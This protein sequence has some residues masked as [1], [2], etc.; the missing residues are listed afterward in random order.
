MLS[1]IRAQGDPAR[2]RRDGGGG[3]DMTQLSDEY[4]NIKKFPEPLVMQT[5]TRDH[6]E[7]RFLP[8]RRMIWLPLQEEQSVMHIDTGKQQDD[9][10]TMSE[11]LGWSFCCPVR[12][13]A[14]RGWCMSSPDR[15]QVR[16]AGDHG[17]RPRSRP[18]V[19]GSRGAVHGVDP[20]GPAAAAAENAAQHVLLAQSRRG[21]WRIRG[22][23][24]SC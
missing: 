20:A 17:G 14:T 9:R 15:A 3:Y 11:G 6:F 4:E 2:R 10:F 7:G 1:Q 16:V 23:R 21:A 13:E 12:G 22:G 8:S 24:L 5:E 18:A 19:H